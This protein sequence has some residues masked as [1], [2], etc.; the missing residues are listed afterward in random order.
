MNKLEEELDL[1]KIHRTDEHT[2]IEYITDGER[3]WLKRVF[4]NKGGFRGF[5]TED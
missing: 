3:L 5:Q 2:T 1:E 4:R